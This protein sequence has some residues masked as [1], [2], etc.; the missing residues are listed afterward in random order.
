MVH[1][2]GLLVQPPCNILNCVAVESPVEV[3]GDV[4][5]MRRRQDVIQRPERVIGRQG[6]DVEHVEC[7]ASYAAFTQNL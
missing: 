2:S 5:K 7:C 3:P 4:T 1:Y 6:F